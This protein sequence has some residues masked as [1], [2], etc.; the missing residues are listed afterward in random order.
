[1]PAPA[2]EIDTI[3]LRRGGRAILNE[4]SLSAAPGHITALLGPNGAGKTT[5]IRCCTGLLTPDSGTIRI[6]GSD[7][8]TAAARG[9][10]GVMPQ[11]TGAW[12]GIRPLELLRY[13][14]G[15]HAHPLPVAEL[16]TELGL[17]GFSSTPYRRLS[18]GQQQLVN[19]AGALIGRPAL[20]FLDEPSAGLDPHVR[21]RVW[22]L[23]RQL[24]EAGL[25]I[26]LTTHSMAEAEALADHVRIMDRGRV[27]ASGTIQ[28]LTATQSLEDLFLQVTSGDAS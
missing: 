9:E 14:A 7:P 15:L 17:D 22:D 8:A 25:S 24:R 12:S 28:E 13:L 26:L 5:T 18:G 6:L 27:S 20:V 2:L 3:S 11:H 19:L 16:A 10:V 1:M 21:R 4:L 23:L